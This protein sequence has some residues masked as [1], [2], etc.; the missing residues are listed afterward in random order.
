[1]GWVR[2]IMLWVGVLVVVA[3]AAAYLLPRQV[4]VERSA[5]IAAPPAT[6]FTILNSFKHFNRWSPW[7]EL[8]PEARYMHE[9]P[10]AGVG[11]KLSWVGNPR[12]LGSG[13]QVIT[14]SE[15]YT[16]LAADVEFGLGGA[17]A[18]QVYALAADGQGTKVSW[19]LEVDLGMNPVARYFALG[20]DGMIAAD[21]DKGL[22]LLKKFAESLPKG[23]FAGLPI[24]VVTVEPVTVTYLPTSSAKDDAA[25]ATAIARAYGEVGAFMKAQ[26]LKQ[27]GAPLTI[28]TGSSATGYLFDAAIPVDRMPPSPARS[29]SRVQV[30]Q[31][32]GGKVLKVALR[33]PYSQIP[34]TYDRIVAYIAA[35]GIDTNGNPWD[36]FA[37]DPTTVKESEILTN[38]YFPIK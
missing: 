29:D 36:E 13:S 19:S 27:A 3:L 5:T 15:P 10:G 1:M 23:D 7:F 9:G 25:I 20:F 31:T 26:G 14:S 12:T 28:D 21:F 16:K 30:K 2:R 22:A 38:I 34:A 8:D 17:P 33:G 24:E 32:Y 6:V 4:R 18:K 35:H 37:N 11:A